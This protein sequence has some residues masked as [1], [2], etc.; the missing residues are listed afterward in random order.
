LLNRKMRHGLQGFFFAH[1]G[2]Q[3]VQTRRGQP[4]RISA[5][6][7]IRHATV[8][9]K[10]RFAPSGPWRASGD[11]WR[12]RCLGQKMNGDVAVSRSGHRQSR[13]CFGRISIEMCPVSNGSFQASMTEVRSQ[14]SESQKSEEVRSQKS[15]VRK[16]EK[17]NA[18]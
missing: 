10:N 16:F 11:W 13:K 7:Q 18:H 4:T 14:K 3:D 15:E 2:M 9:G 12:G 5:R 8:S 6:G 1:P 17:E